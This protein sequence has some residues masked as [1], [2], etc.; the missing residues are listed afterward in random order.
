M[1]L[2]SEFI[3][4]VTDTESLLVPSG[5][6]KFS[7]IIKGNSTLGAIL[8]LLRE[9]RTEQEIITAMCQKYDATKDVIERDVRHVLE[10]LRKTGALED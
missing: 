8:E 1:K 10:Q 6:A 2:S 3:P 9:D 5:N 7:G 4:H